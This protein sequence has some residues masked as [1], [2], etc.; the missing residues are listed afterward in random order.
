M[1]GRRHLP[2]AH[3]AIGSGEPTSRHGPLTWW[4]RRSRRADLA[5]LTRVRDGLRRLDAEPDGE[6]H[7]S[8]ATG[9]AP[10]RKAN[11]VRKANQPRRRRFP[12]LCWPGGTT[13][14]RT[15][16]AGA[17]A[18]DAVPGPRW[19]VSGGCVADLLGAAAGR[20]AEVIAALGEL[21]VG[22]PVPR[23]RLAHQPGQVLAAVHVSLLDRH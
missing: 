2:G 9:P 1:P 14:H 7:A 15:D 12:P 3:E 6:D 21:V 8:P 13:R 22:A 23:H 18:A 5:V 17:R 20:D 16:H 11:P 4:H 19:A 10:A